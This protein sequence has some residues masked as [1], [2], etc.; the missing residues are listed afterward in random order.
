[1]PSQ[2]YRK[3]Q[4]FLVDFHNS[5]IGDKGRALH[6]PFLDLL[7]SYTCTQRDRILSCWL[8]QRL[9]LQTRTHKLGLLKKGSKEKGELIVSVMICRYQNYRNIFVSNFFWESDI[10]KE[11]SWQWAITE[12]G[13]TH[14]H[15][16]GKHIS[17]SV[18]EPKLCV[19]VSGSRQSPKSI[20]K[21]LLSKQNAHISH[22]N[23]NCDPSFIMGENCYSFTQSR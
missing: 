12:C 13:F 10:L 8:S 18:L 7:L 17:I 16:V 23:R 3:Q 1:M 6:I 22:V 4:K 20:L 9:N 2:V 15:V 11:K 5:G 14:C 21:H 19:V